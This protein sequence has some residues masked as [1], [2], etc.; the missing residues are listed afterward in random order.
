MAWDEI[1]CDSLGSG[2]WQLPTQNPF[3]PAPFVQYHKFNSSND[4][5][6]TKPMCLKEATPTPS[7]HCKPKWFKSN[8]IL[9]ATKMIQKL[10]PKLKTFLWIWVKNKTMT[11]DQ[12]DKIWLFKG[13][14]RIPC[15][16]LVRK[17]S[18]EM[19]S[20]WE[21]AAWASTASLLPWWKSASR[22]SQHKEDSK[23]GKW[24]HNC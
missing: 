5:L 14:L 22:W 1:L 11:S 12:W 20:I 17:L 21:W 13:S 16:A 23:D 9:F 4:Q 18:E 8:P 6:P 2:H 19:P 10:R 15:L 3:H 24:S 7:S